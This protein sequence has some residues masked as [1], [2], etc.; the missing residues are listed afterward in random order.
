VV[1]FPPPPTRNHHTPC[2]R[3][4]GLVDREDNKPKTFESSKKGSPSEWKLN[5][6]LSA[7]D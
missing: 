6:M 4:G 2:W 7:R 3:K 1:P 5:E